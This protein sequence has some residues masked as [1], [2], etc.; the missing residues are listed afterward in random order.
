MAI[1]PIKSVSKVENMSQNA[2][3][4]GRKK[5]DSQP[6]TVK[7]KD[8]W[9]TPFATDYESVCKRMLHEAVVK[10]MANPEFDFRDQ[11]VKGQRLWYI[12]YN[13]LTNSIVVEDITVHTVYPRTLIGYVEAGE[14]RCVGYSEREM[15]FDTPLE[16]EEVMRGF[17]KN[18]QK[19]D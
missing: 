16:A 5:A 18:V 9:T 1:E 19:N 11:Y 6:K 7:N 4:R 8:I 12:N 15:L 13:E 2:P 3:K 10:K 17:R 14:A